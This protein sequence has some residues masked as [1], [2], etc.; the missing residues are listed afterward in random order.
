MIRNFKM[1]RRLIWWRSSRKSASMSME[2]EKRWSIKKKHWKNSSVPREINK[3][4]NRLS[5]DSLCINLIAI[6]MI[7]L[8]S[9]SSANSW[10][11]RVFSTDFV[12]R[13]QVF[14]FLKSFPWSWLWSHLSCLFLLRFSCAQRCR[15]AFGFPLCQRFRSCWDIPLFIP[16]SFVTLLLA[17][18]WSSC[19]E[20]ANLLQ[21]SWSALTFPVCWP[22]IWSVQVCSFFCWRLHEAFS[23]LTL[24]NFIWP[25]TLS[26]GCCNHWSISQV[27]KTSYA[28]LVWSLFSADDFLPW[29]ALTIH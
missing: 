24:A 23:L 5:Y 8:P 19:E 15:Q 14:F 13:L 1:K 17:K 28:S 29:S 18:V 10:S 9:S 11:V 2:K 16:C 6:S 27:L 3:K 25:C 4:N 26:E 22:F 12:V 7:T 20:K 21:P